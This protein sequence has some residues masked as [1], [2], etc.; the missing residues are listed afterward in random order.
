MTIEMYF[1]N[2]NVMKQAFAKAGLAS[3]RKELRFE[4]VVNLK[5]V[6]SF[7]EAPKV[8]RFVQVTTDKEQEILDMVPER[9]V[10]HTKSFR[11]HLKIAA[12]VSLAYERLCKTLESLDKAMEEDVVNMA[13]RARLVKQIE[14]KENQ[15]AYHLDRI[16]A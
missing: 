13:Y 12:V 2:G 8:E 1:D 14:D 5:P 15:L 11:K 6:K 16:G 9:E 4:K 7:K 3:A 10:K